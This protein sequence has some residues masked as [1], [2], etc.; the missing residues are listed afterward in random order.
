MVDDGAPRPQARTIGGM[1]PSTKSARATTVSSTIPSPF[2]ALQKINQAELHRLN[3]EVSAVRAQWHQEAEQLE[4]EDKRR[5]RIEIELQAEITHLKIAQQARQKSGENPL[6]KILF[7]KDEDLLTPGQRTSLSPKDILDALET[8]KNELQSILHGRIPLLHRLST[9]L[10]QNSKL[11]WG[12]VAVVRS[13]AVAALQEWVF[14]TDFPNFCRTGDPRLLTAYRK[15]I[16]VHDGWEHLHNLE[17]AAYASLLDDDTFKNGVVS[18]KADDLAARLS[19]TLAP[20]FSRSP[21]DLRTRYRRFRFKGMFEAAL[22]LKVATSI[23]DDRYEFVVHLPGTSATKATSISGT[24]TE[25]EIE[26]NVSDS[27]APL[28]QLECG[29]CKGSR[30]CG[31]CD[32][33][34]PTVITLQN[35]MEQ[36]HTGMVELLASEGASESTSK[37]RSGS[38]DQVILPDR[39]NTTLTTAV[40]GADPELK[41]HDC[42]AK[43]KGIG[44]LRRHRND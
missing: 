18:R 41:C 21:D 33:H 43:F 39:D 36:D 29:S 24:N 4:K 25:S 11:K 20:L 15:V 37:N 28:R 17:L 5:K 19:K 34:F 16:L 1:S 10:L 23:T 35:H 8:I 26:S 2:I 30:Q 6:E 7:A 9:L 44:F 31:T 42:G 40:K 27:D 12:T 3:A 32:K 14:A 22:R 38:D 13:L